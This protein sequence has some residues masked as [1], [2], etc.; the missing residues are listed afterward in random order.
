MYGLDNGQVYDLETGETVIDAEK[1][2][3]EQILKMLEGEDN[4]QSKITKNK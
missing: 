2:T 4:E 1:L 3:M